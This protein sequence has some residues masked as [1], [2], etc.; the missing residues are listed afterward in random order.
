MIYGLWPYGFV[1]CLILASPGA[2]ASLIAP[3]P[4]SLNLISNS[5]LNRFGV[6]EVAELDTRGKPKPFSSADE[7]DVNLVSERARRIP[8]A[9]SRYTSD[10][11]SQ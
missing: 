1:S 2:S 4:N 11:R 6:F 5:L 8:G 3:Q 7:R 10:V 9:F